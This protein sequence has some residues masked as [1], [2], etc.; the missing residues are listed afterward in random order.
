M[1]AC[2]LRTW[3]CRRC[4][5]GLYVYGGAPLALAG[6]AFSLLRL[7]NS[8]IDASKINVDYELQKSR[9]I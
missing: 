4:R 8:V 9:I 6:G 7:P 1:A 3:N 2:G 5:L